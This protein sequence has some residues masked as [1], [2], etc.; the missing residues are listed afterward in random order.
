M[1]GGRNEWIMWLQ[2]ALKLT[3]VESNLKDITDVPDQAAIVRQYMR[4]TAQINSG[5]NIVQLVKRAL[6]M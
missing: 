2:G 3:S 1:K 5:K 6:Q 4:F